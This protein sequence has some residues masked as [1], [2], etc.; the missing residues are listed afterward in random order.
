MTQDPEYRN[1]LQRFII[2]VIIFVLVFGGP[3]LLFLWM[4]GALPGSATPVPVP[5]QTG[6]AAPSVGETPTPQEGVSG[7]II[8]L[9]EG[10][11]LAQTSERLP[12]ATGEPLPAS[13]AERILRLLPVL[14]TQP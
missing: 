12:V 10:N 5:F 13:E 9:S 11:P 3:L 2:A 4:R 1:G 14:P 8:R 7:M 6:T